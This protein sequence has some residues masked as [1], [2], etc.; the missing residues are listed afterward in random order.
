[1]VADLFAIVPGL[2][3]G[4]NAK[5]ISREQNCLSKIARC[6]IDVILLARRRGWPVGA[7]FRLRH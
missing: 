4:R 7:A 5:G 3:Q 1:V 6:E 2:C